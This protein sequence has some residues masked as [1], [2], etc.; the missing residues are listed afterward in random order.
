MRASLNALNVAGLL[1]AVSAFGW[2]DAI[3]GQATTL[4]DARWRHIGP[5]VFGGRISDLAVDPA[6]PSVIY[7]GA[8]SGGVFKSIN[9]GGTWEPVFDESGGSQSIGAVAV[10]PSDPQIVWVGTGEANNRQSSSWG[11][12]V[13]RS[14]DGG[15]SWKAMGLAGTHHI[16]R[17]VIDPRNPDV[18]YVAALG[19]LWGTNAERGVYRT[20]DGGTS[21]QRVLAIDAMT[22]VVDITLDPDGRTLLA[23]AYQR[24]RRAFGFTGGGP[25]GGIYRSENG[26][27]TWNRITEGL[28]AG[29]VGRIG[30]SQSRSQPNVV[31]AVVEH[32][33]KGGVYR[34][35]DRGRSWRRT[36][37]LNPRPM[38]YSQ[39]RVDP[40]NADRVWLLDA[41]LWQSTDGGKTFSSD[42]TGIGIHVDHHAMWI[43][44]ADPSHMLLGNDGGLYVTHDG[45]RSWRF[46]DNLPIAQ[47][48]DISVDDGEPYRIY[49]G[50]Q[51]NGTWSAPSRTYNEGG[52]FNS[53][54][55]H[56]AFGDGFFTQPDPDDPRFVYA[57]SQNGRAYVVNVTTGEQRLI[58]PVPPDTAETYSFGW[59]TPMLV[60]PH[61]AKTYYYGG[62]RLFR[63]RDRGHSWQ[64]AS[65][66]FSPRAG[67]TTIPIMGMA[68]DSTTLS[69]DDGVSDYG[70]ITTIAES[71]KQAGLLLVGTDDGAVH[72]SSDA[73]TTWS[74]ITA[75][76]GLAAR[77]W[78][79]RVV[80]SQHDARAMY[81]AFDGHQDDDFSPYLFGSSDGGRTWR[82]LSG[83]IPHG[84]VINTVA[85]H[86]A[87]PRV[88]L[89]GT[90]QGLLVS[91]DGG[92]SWKRASGNLPP[93]SI[94]DIV[95]HP[96]TLDIV[97]GTHG[98]GLIV[99]DD[100]RFL[101]AGDPE[102][103]TTRVIPPGVATMAYARRSLPAA[104]AA[105]F[106]GDNPPQGAVITYLVGR[107]GG[108]SATASPADSA[109]IE[110]T[111]SSGEV[112]RVLKGS[113]A[114]GVH[115]VSW[116]LRHA[117]P[118]VPVAADAVWFGPPR[119]TWV[120]PGSYTVTVRLRDVSTS[121]TL[122]VRSDPRVKVSAEE[123]AA[124]HAMGLRVHEL[125]RAWNDADKAIQK[126]DASLALRPAG[127][128]IVIA[129]KATVAELKERFRSGWLSLKS[130]VLD[131]HGAT[132]SATAAPTESQTRMLA[133]LEGEMRQ[134][135]AGLNA[136]ITGIMGDGTSAVVPPAPR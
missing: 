38:Y 74:D 107:G 39:L 59:S 75:R 71:P 117:L 30:L 37:P 22:G 50:T 14:M 36:N 69:R 17:I 64:V 45:A 21:W 18:V 62:H 13:Y 116:D 108:R 92:A 73:G 32:R 41:Y 5:A 135:I 128:S 100:T 6:N 121:T 25:G 23:G 91:Y 77:R 52:I 95:V 84:Y 68:R 66:A 101:A 129:Q 31:Y 134:S 93:V 54:M 85:E 56:L 65:P 10:A 49:G 19:H 90:E 110:I 115:R 131:L 109:T 80:A 63:T 7:V 112:I 67:W 70:T 98:R 29:H 47:Y 57:N 27:D 118:Y 119:G 28:P 120:L 111:S 124:R 123:L 99:L 26:G 20:R 76:F 40:T 105:R 86:P 1:A 34:S 8:A 16:G 53:D 58:R 48:Y 44:P 103:G 89:A 15:R 94:D 46:L 114:P 130:R 127:D 61:D 33:A 97:L 106:A 104:G 42:S 60:S 102:A 55:Q 88:L 11:N 78:V 126:L 132:Q 113:A 133:Q 2:P 51:D 12:G 122:E 72:L 82:S 79:S 43:D 35:D 136:A 125:L 81:V 87:N 24:Q 83:G 3:A 96:R 9:R 4:G